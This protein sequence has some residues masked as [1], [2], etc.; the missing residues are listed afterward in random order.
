MSAGPNRARR[1]TA[2]N[3]SPG[4]FAL[5]SFSYASIS[6]DIVFVAMHETIHENA[7]EGSIF[8]RR[9][10]ECQNRFVAGC[11]GLHII[12]SIRGWLFRFDSRIAADVC[13]CCKRKS[14]ESFFQNPQSEAANRKTEPPADA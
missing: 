14:I 2:E 3:D 8:D 13:L 7:T 4:R 11:F 9:G 5:R 10:W 12:L 1:T 6:S